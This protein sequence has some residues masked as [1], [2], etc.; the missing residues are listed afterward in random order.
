M[1]DILAE[2]ALRVTV[3]AAGVAVVLRTLRLRSPSLVHAAWTAVVFVMLVLPMFVAWGPAFV[4]P[5]LPSHGAGRIALSAADD[6]APLAVDPRPLI[7]PAT[8]RA[9]TPITWTAAAMAMYLAGVGLFLLR[10]A[11]GL[12]GARAIRRGAVRAQGRLTHPACLA[13]L[14]VG[15]IAPAVIL[16]PDWERWGDAEL[17]A[18]L[19]HEEEHVRRHDPLVAAFALLNRAIFWFHPL[20]W[21]LQREISRRSEE[22]CDAAVISG[23]HDRQIYASCL[24]RFAR[25]VAEAGGRIAPMSMAMP[26]PGLK[27][28]LGILARPE[29]EQPS[30][31][32]VACAAAACAA[33]VVVC[34]AV[35]PTAAAVQDVPSAVPDQGVWAVYTSDHFEIVHAGLPS[36]RVADA[37]RAAEAAYARV[38]AALR[39][40]IPRRV[41]IVLVRRDFDISRTTA[42]APVLLPRTEAPQRRLVIS[43]ESLDQRTGR[44]VHELTHDFAF[45]IIP[46]ASRAAPSVIEGLAEHQRG[47]WEAEDLRRIRAAAAAGAIPS[48]T[49]LATTERY[50]AHALFDFIAVQYGPEGIRRLLF[51]M[52]AHAT[53]EQAAPVAF[54]V[55]LDQ[56]NE[57]VRRYVTTRFTQP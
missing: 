34:A 41:T 49:G 30:R 21:W 37:A 43:L 32:R 27:E 23:G 24:L 50:W 22:A 15:V 5:L 46:D 9:E 17:S 48:V 12:R 4:A 2:A 3:L 20:A 44:I 57:G 45:D 56:F 36:D 54:S 11:V 47:I 25:R 7:A 38:S 10:L 53:L 31:S 51:A 39:H 40:D 33:L 1:I 52:R 18:V 13:P 8:P 19:A 35:A 16:P 6:V 14:T 26:G 55:T 29:T 42:R 28:R